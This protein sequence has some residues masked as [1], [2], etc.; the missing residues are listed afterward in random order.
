LTTAKTTLGYMAPELFYKNIRSV[1]YKVDVYSF[2]MLLMEM[3]DRR[4]NWND[5]AKHSSQIYF[6]TWVYDQLHNRNDIEM[7]DVTEEKKKIITKMIIV[8]L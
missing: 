2:E 7:D 6:P 8:A 1:S 3:V 5:F 4:K